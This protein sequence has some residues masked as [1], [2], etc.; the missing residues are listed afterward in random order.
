MVMVVSMRTRAVPPAGAVVCV[1][2]MAAGAKP[3]TVSL[4]RSNAARTVA[5]DV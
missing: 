5:S 3:M 4:N 1:I 2:A